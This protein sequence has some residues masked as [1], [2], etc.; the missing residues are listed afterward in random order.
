MF[1]GYSMSETINGVH[2]TYEYSSDNVLLTKSISADA[3]YQF[4]NQNGPAR[5]C[6]DRDG[7]G[8][9]IAEEYY[10]EDNLHRIDG[11]AIIWYD[12]DG[13]YSKLEYRYKNY[14]QFN[15]LEELQMYIKCELLD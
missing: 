10:I 12:K 4:H 13:N 7:S 1:K 14:K 8:R 11:P 5:I 15:S 6:Y 3:H 2:Y 9:I